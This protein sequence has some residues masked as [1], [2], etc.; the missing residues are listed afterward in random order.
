[1]TCRMLLSAA[2]S[3]VAA[4]ALDATAL[5]AQTLDVKEWAVEWEGRPR[6]PAVD[7]GGRVWFVGQAGNYIGVFDPAGETFRR[8]E[9]EPNTRPHNLI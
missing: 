2:A 9:L 3:L 6:D 5:A 1:M 4:S 8:Y 7:A